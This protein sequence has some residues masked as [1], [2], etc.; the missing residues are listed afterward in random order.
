M[1]EVW[2]KIDL[3]KAP[4]D[5]SQLDESDYPI[6]PI[7]ALQKINIDN[8]LHT[9]ENKSNIILNKR[10]YTMSYNIEHHFDRLK[11]LYE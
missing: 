1:I 9:I 3:L 4:I 5:Y 2:N 7:S 11:W 6:V 10:Q 8:L